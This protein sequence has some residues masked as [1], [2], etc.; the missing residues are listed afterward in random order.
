MAQQ[1]ECQSVDQKAASLIPGQDTSLSCG[2]GP[3][4]GACE[5]Q[6]NQYISHASMFLSL[7]LSKNKYII[8]KTF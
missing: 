6:P 2:P 3:Q 4:K 5:R 1:T 8:K 7:P